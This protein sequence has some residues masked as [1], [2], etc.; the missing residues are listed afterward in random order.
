MGQETD[1]TGLLTVAQG[2]VH[3][4]H[5]GAHAFVFSYLFCCS[6]CIVLLLVA[7]DVEVLTGTSS[8]IRNGLVGEIN[9]HLHRRVLADRLEEF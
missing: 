8:R 4:L 3:D 7:V 1:A 6:H 5:E 9:C 2:G